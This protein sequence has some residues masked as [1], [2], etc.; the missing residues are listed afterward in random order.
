[1]S[2]PPDRVTGVRL[3]VY[4]RVWA[5]PAAR[6]I[7]LLGLLARLPMTGAMVVITF[8]VV[9]KLDPRYGA[10]GII[11]AASTIAIAAS[12]PW[13]GRLLDRFGLRR[14][15]LPSLIVVPAC[16]AIA[17]FSSYP[18][19]LV[20]VVVAGVFNAPMF[21]I[22]RLA[23]LAVVTESDRKTALALDS[24]FVEIAFMAGPAL[25]IW[26][27]TSWDTAWGLFTLQMMAVAGTALIWLFDPPLSNGDAGPDQPRRGHWLTAPVAGVLLATGT[28]T[29]VLGGIDLGVVAGLRALDQPASIG[30][31]LAVWALGSAVGGLVYGASSRTLPVPLLLAGLSLTTIPIAF[32]GNA[33]TMA[34]LALC[35]GFFIAPMITAT[36]DAL[37]RVVPDRVR[38]EVL[39]WHGALLMTG[40]AAGAPLLGAVIDRFGWGAAFW[41]GG[42]LG[43]LV[44][45]PVIALVRRTPQRERECVRPG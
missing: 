18:V 36:V 37:T 44:V 41:G 10:A 4:G 23:V 24:V 40:T 6:A 2:V 28:T 20:L 26:L 35:S 3:S 12:A 27:A 7:L 45:L 38:G 43:L 14:T 29:V 32:S 33:W 5:N 25:G 19:L 31:V 21:S 16:W 34:A 11:S 30:W 13:R 8:H 17:P 42:V 39:G 9:E 22:V 1:M 15:L